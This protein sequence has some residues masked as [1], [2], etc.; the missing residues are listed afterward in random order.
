MF[1]RCYKK[2]MTTQSLKEQFK[3][4][5]IAILSL[6]IA[7]VALGYTSWREEVTEH[8]RNT[9]VAAFEVLK[10]LGELQIIINQTIYQPKSLNTSPFLGWGH[11]SII[12][13]MGSLL[14]TPIPE[15]TADLVKTWGQTWEKLSDNNDAQDAITSEIDTCRTATIAVIQSLR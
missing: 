15:Q 2:N 11:V 9:R 14:P 10:N 3:Q 13:D 5:F 4:H 8:N 1:S 6:F 7:V 12:G